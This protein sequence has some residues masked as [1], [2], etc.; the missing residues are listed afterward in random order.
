MN[1]PTVLERSG[2]LIK[3]DRCVRVA[4]RMVER[5]EKDES[6]WGDKLVEIKILI[7][8]AEA[9]VRKGIVDWLAND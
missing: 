9:N 4:T 7:S 3:I 1:E 6:I 8:Q 2:A 5:Q